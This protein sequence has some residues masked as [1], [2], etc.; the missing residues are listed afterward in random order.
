MKVS[1]VD[2]FVAGSETTS[3]TIRWSV[4]YLI[5]NPDVLAKVQKEIDEVV[6][7]DTLPSLEHKEK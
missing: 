7:K 5:N 3:T 1:I 6:P 4:L 2:L